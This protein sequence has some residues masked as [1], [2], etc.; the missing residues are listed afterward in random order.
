[1]AIRYSGELKMHVVLC[2]DDTY[3]VTFGTLCPPITGVR[4]SPF[5]QGRYALDSREAYDRIAQ[6]GISFAEHEH[7]VE[8]YGHCETD[9]AGEVII[10]RRRKHDEGVKGGVGI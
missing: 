2:K 5:D 1:M 4:L 7:H 8:L 10:T 3:S 9:P 6:A